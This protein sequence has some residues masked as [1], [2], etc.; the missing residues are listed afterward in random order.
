MT[1]LDTG[2]NKV[3]FPAF[4]CFERFHGAI[5]LAHLKAFA[6]EKFGQESTVVRIGANDEV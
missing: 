5:G 3:E 6:G 2:N 1:H 4:D